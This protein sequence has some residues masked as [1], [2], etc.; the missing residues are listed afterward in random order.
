MYNESGFSVKNFILKI[1]LV[2][3]FVFL[4]MWLFPMPNLKPV[5]D[6][7]FAD[8]V[9]TMT[10]AV[11]SY[12]TVE[13]LPKEVNDT[14]KMTLDEMLAMKLVL[15]IAD[16]NDVLCDGQ[17]SYVEIMKTDTEYVIKTNLSC[18]TNSDYVIEHMG[19]YDICGDSCTK[20]ET[21]VA[22]APQTVKPTTKPTVTKPV[23]KPT[24]TTTTMY[25]L[26]RTWYKGYT[27]NT[28][29]ATTQYKH[30]KYGT[31]SIFAGYNYSCPSEYTQSGNTCYK[32]TTSYS[33][34]CPVGYTQSGSTCY[35]NTTSYTY[36]CPSGYTQSGSGSS[37][38]CS[39]NVTKSSG[40]SCTSGTIDFETNQCKIPHTTYTYSCP[41]G[42]SS[43]G[44]GSS[45][46]CSRSVSSGTTTQYVGTGSGKSIP[47]STSTYS[48]VSTGSTS[49]KD[50]N[51]CSSYIVYTY[52]IYKKVSTT[53]TQNADP[54][55]TAKTTYTYAPLKY[56]ETTSTVTA[57]PISTPSTTTSYASLVSSSSTS[58]ST[59]SLISTAQYTYRTYVVDSKW[60]YNSYESGYTMVDKQTIAGNTS[61][62]YTPDWVLTLPAGYTKTETKAEYKWATTNTESGWTYT[63]V[64]KQVTK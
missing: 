11:K 49:V 48:Y 27:S 36:S 7:L 55:K 28:S 13:R 9:Q 44:S 56:N 53:S 19:C 45:M 42:Y 29:A 18:S 17:A 47:S 64:T 54:I 61:T 37:M 62:V 63:G 20:E 14:V 24:T 39:K 60:T 6:R 35:K 59:A 31:E 41:S 38:T 50:C 30:V 2:I 3:L 46:T 5:Y 1:I 4:L 16:S 33:Y 34:S 26:T 58:T 25:Q 15:P 22:V 21:P 12:Y 10:D 8:N 57:N 40:Y 23:E 32:N 52:K 43:S 51:A